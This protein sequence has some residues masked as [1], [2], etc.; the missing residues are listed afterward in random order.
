MH[1]QNWCLERYIWQQDL[2]PTKIPEEKVIKS[3]IHGVKSSGNQADRVL[4]ETAKLSQVEY[5]KVN[6]I[7]RND[8]SVDDCISG[9]QP[10]NEALKRA[11]ELELVLNRR[12]FVLKG[13]TFSN[14]NH[15]LMTS[16]H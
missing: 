2:D 12:G 10:V 6:E 11:D 5:P 3:L 8:I 4:R 13:I 16:F 14:Q 7:V 9:E 15:C 1:E